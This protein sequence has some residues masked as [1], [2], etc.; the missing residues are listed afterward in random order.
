M[1]TLFFK[2]FI[3]PSNSVVFRR[4][5]SKIL[6]GVRH[7]YAVLLIGNKRKGLYDNYSIYRLY[8]KKLITLSFAVELFF[9]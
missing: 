1:M 6:Q 7:L 2:F 9:I 8:K 3:H 4:S 5:I